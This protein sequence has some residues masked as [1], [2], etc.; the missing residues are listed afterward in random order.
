M[1]V[2]RDDTE[3]RAHLNVSEHSDNN[4]HLQ[5]R[6]YPVV[7]TGNPR[8]PSCSQGDCCK[9]IVLIHVSSTIWCR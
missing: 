5:A 3:R 4:R 8:L 1:N 6:L 2:S 7:D 9:D